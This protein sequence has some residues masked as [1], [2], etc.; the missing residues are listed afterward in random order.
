MSEKRVTAPKQSSKHRKSASEKLELLITV[1]N[2]NKAEYFVDLIQSFDVNLQLTVLSRGTAN[3]KMME[4]LGLT[5][6]EKMVIF[7]VI[8]QRNSC[9][10]LAMLE[11]K[12]KTICGGNGIAF[13]VSL[14]SVIGTLIYGFLSNNKAVM[15]DK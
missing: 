6:N 4:L 15:E 3:A 13:T 14:S 2:R 1:V 7:S 12:F 8:R 10:A 9:D 11:E 5:D